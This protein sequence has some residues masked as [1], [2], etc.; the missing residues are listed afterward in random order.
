MTRIRIV[1]L[2][3][4]LLTM[5]ACRQGEIAKAGEPKRPSFPAADC[6]RGV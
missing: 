2:S 1:L 5:L 4:A 6:K 3:C